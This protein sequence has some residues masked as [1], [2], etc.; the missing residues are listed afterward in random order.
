MVDGDQDI[1]EEGANVFFFVI[2]LFPLQSC[3]DISNAVNIPIC[4]LS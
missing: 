1:D 2:A 4:N 3:Y